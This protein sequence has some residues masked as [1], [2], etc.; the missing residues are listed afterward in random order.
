[1]SV[2]LFCDPDHP[3]SQ[4]EIR[5]SIGLRFSAWHSLRL[6]LEAN[7]PI[8]PEPVFGG[9]NYGWC[10]RYRKGGKT[11][12]CLFPQKGYFVAQIVLGR[13]EVERALEARLALHVATVLREAKQ[14]HD[15]RWLFIQ[16]RN[17]RDAEDVLQL[18]QI[19]RPISARQK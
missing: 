4:K 13:V 5:S 9:R 8:A 12:V 14:F 7:Y 2:G 1:M 6:F 16:V 3:P 18:I 15:G 19:K 17:K 11:L 10:I